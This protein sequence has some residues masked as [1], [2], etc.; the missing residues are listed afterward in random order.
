MEEPST[1]E[2][3]QHRWARDIREEGKVRGSYLV[4]E[5]RSGTTRK[6]EPFISL[7]LGDK[8]GDI[9]GRIWD[10]AQTL[11]A[12]FREG[13]VV[14]IEGQASLYRNQAQ[15]TVNSLKTVEVYDPALFLEV[16]E[17]PPSEMLDGLK[18]TLKAVKNRPLRSLIDS[19]MADKGFLSQ[20]SQAPAAKGFHHSHL[21]G[22]LEHTLSVCQL[23]HRVADQYPR[24]DRD[25]LLTA[26]FLHDIGK[27]RELKYLRQVDYSD[28][29]RLLGHLVIGVSMLNDK[30]RQLKRFPD[31][32]TVRLTHMILS[33]HGEY[34]FGSPKRP[35][36]LE[37]FALHFIDDLDAKMNGIARFMDRDRQEGEWTDFNRMYERFFLKGKIVVE[38][39]SPLADDGPEGQQGRLFSAI[40]P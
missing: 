29:G 33:H 21:G 32:L 26:A 37:A 2:S 4:K 23:A 16:S 5:K 19:F 13:D 40:S 35:K 36:F 6:G 11:S 27:V 30:I 12:L 20:F 22:L 3:G 8:T 9:E 10:N 1:Q 39:E 28:E 15:I 24:L 7:T 14:E 17:R 25:L 18:E 34:A 31:D 38:D